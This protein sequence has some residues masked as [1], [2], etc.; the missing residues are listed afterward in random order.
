MVLISKRIIIGA[1]QENVENKNS[2]EKTIADTENA[3][4]KVRHD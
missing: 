1:I 3:Y 4:M 2:Y